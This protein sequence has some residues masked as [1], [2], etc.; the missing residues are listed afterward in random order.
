MAQWL[1]FV[2]VVMN[3]RL[4]VMRGIFACYSDC[5]L[6]LGVGLCTRIMSSKSG[7]LVFSLCDVA[8]VRF[9]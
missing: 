4:H 5:Q 1:A 7:N 6:F 8:G 3:L 2:S 9:I